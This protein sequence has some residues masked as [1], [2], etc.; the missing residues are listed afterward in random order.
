ML[1]EASSSL[2][3]QNHRALFGFRLKLFHFV[4]VLSHASDFTP[5]RVLLCIDSSQPQIIY[6]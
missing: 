3:V 4:E 6:S 2:L 1:D 5:Y